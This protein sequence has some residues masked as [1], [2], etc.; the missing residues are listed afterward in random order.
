M[1]IDRKNS[2]RVNEE[3]AVGKILAARTVTK[4]GVQIQAG[5]RV[6]IVD[7]VGCQKPMPL[8]PDVAHLQLQV[9]G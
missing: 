9:S 4:H 2:S 8:R 7:V 3:R 1:E 6:S 5:L